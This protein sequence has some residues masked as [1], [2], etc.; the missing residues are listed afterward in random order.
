MHLGCHS[1]TSEGGSANIESILVHFACRSAHFAVNS[2]LFLGCSGH[3][4]G[5]SVHCE[6]G[7]AY[8][9][10]ISY[11][12]LAF[13]HNLRDVLSVF[14]VSLGHAKFIDDPHIFG[15]APM[16]VGNWHRF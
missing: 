4:V 5:S 16:C 11:H 8:F 6:S 2:V 7:A 14:R 12:L 9:T 15:L 13:L 1:F 3:F 10:G